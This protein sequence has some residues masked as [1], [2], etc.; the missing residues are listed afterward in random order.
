MYR[1]NRWTAMLI[2]A[3]AALALAGNMA[4]AQTKPFQIVG[5]GVAP[6][7]FPGPGSSAPHWSIGEG[8][9]L[10]F[11]EGEGGVYNASLDLTPNANGDFTGTFRSDGPYVF[12]GEDGDKLAVYYGTPDGTTPTGTYDLVHV[13]GKVG[14]G[15]TYQ[16]FFLAEFVPYD[17]ECTGKFNGVTGGWTMYATTEPFVLGST[18]PLGYEWSGKG[19]LTFAKQRR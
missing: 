11:Y 13:S 9:F 1:S 14:F 17:Q 8:S 3:F 19:S 6:D 10:G 4:V 15:G 2:G 7:G 16:A 12:T 5:V 18:D